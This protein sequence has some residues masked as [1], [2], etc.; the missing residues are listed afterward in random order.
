MENLVFLAFGKGER[1]LVGESA[2]LSESGGGEKGF[3]LAAEF[4]ELGFD[5][6]GLNFAHF[7]ED[8][9]LQRGL[10]G[11]GIIAEEG[12]NLPLAGLDDAMNAEV[13][14]GLFQLKEFGEL[15]GEFGEL[16]HVG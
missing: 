12:L 10:I 13:E 16:F 2:I 11:V 14:I 5:I 6:S 3:D 1:V 15:G 7:A 4:F 9:L 8:D